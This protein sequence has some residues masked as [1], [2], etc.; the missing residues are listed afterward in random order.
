MTV[1]VA[2]ARPPAPLDTTDPY[3]RTFGA[4]ADA[5]PPPA[6]GR[7]VDPAWVLVAVAAIASGAALLRHAWVR[8]AGVS[9]SHP[10][11]AAAPTAAAPRAPAIVAATPARRI[12]RLRVGDRLEFA[13]DASG[14]DVQYRWTVDEQSAGSGARWTYAPTPTEAGRRQVTVAAIGTGGVAERSWTVRV[15]PARPPRIVAS[16]PGAARVDVQAGTDVSL[17]V[18]ARPATAGER[19]AYTWTVDGRPVGTGATVVVPTAKPGALAVRVAVTSNL[20]SDVAHEWRIDVAPAP[21]PAAAPATEA[22][23]AEPPPT[24][25][26]APVA[27]P[28]AT[29]P[30]P[31][32]PAAPPERH[33]SVPRTVSPPPA[34]SSAPAVAPGTEAVQAFLDRYVAAWQAHDVD[35]LRRLG[36]VTTEDQV[37]V[38]RK[39]FASIKD[40]EVTVSLVD[41]RMDGDRTVIHFTKRD[42]FRDPVGR[43]VTKESPPLER[44]LIAGPDGLRFAP[45][46]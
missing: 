26:A 28:E 31:T 35:A 43:L 22:K 33:A 9:S 10:S 4:L 44:A 19:L 12:A 39:Y 15:R 20:G 34:P 11:H 27:K 36:Q 13:A 23:P 7:S 17:A 2:A 41:V 16:V 40:L 3:L 29:S 5:A 32:E 38:L 24:A 21:E 46:G 45:G 8:P 37:A 6:T 14:D 30:P 1:A 42:R 25:G 18:T